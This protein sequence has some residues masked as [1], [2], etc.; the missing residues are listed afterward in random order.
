MQ[1]GAAARVEVKL[2]SVIKSGGSRGIRP[3]A[4]DVSLL[5]PDA[6]TELDLQLGRHLC[7]VCLS[8]A[9]CDDRPTIR[10]FVF[11]QSPVEHKLVAAGPVLRERPLLFFRPSW[12]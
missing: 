5:A 9:S 11:S 2:N 7:S 6:I 1:V 10:Q 4:A 8:I 3:Y 12:V